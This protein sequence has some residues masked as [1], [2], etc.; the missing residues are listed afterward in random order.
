[1]RRLALG[2]AATAFSAVLTAVG[3]G[4]AHA[5]Q[6]VD[7]NYL[8][9]GYVDYGDTEAYIWPVVDGSHKAS[10]AEVDYGSYGASARAECE[11]DN[12]GVNWYE[13]TIHVY[14]G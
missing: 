14:A 9:T 5:G 10:Y 2:V 7:F 3:G 13:S 1:M 12:G 11:R 4:V 6:V 8:Y